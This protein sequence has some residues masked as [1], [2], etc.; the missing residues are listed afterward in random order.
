M[1]TQNTKTY[2][3]YGKM[4]KFL[5]VT[6]VRTCTNLV[7]FERWST[8]KAAYSIVQ[9]IASYLKKTRVTLYERNRL[10][11]TI[12]SINKVIRTVKLCEKYNRILT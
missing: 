4:Q 5:N 2:T 12:A 9:F 8:N 3:L 6:A 11:T 7:H 10:L 1:R